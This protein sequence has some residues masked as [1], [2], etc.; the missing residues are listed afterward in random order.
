M[1][2]IDFSKA[3]D[4]LAEALGSAVSV[5]FRRIDCGVFGD[6]V[7]FDI[8]GEVAYRVWRKGLVE[9]IYFDTWRNPEHKEIICE[10][11][12]EEVW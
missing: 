2:L 6:R 4:Y 1:F 11:N 9:K 3:L 5:C 10:G 8:D 12:G 7:T